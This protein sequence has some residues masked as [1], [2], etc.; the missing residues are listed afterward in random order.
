M[1]LPAAQQPG[2][3]AAVAEAHHQHFQHPQTG[4][5]RQQDKGN[6]A[7]AAQPGDGLINGKAAEGRAASSHQWPKK[8]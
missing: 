3:V 4:D 5:G 1:R 6:D 7:D 2:A 8:I